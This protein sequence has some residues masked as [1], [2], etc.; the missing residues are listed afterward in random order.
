[1]PQPSIA[2][3][4][5]TS[6]DACNAEWFICSIRSWLICHVGST[7]SLNVGSDAFFIKESPP[8]Y[9]CEWVH[10]TAQGPA[11]DFSPELLLSVMKILIKILQQKL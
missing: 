11:C 10:L 9:V 7:E 4:Y 6:G 8:K 5:V 2:D 1:M 3:V